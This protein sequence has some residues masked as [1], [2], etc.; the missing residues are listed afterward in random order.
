M[1]QYSISRKETSEYTKEQILGELGFI[2][3]DVLGKSPY[4]VEG[5]VE[6]K[7]ERSIK[8]DTSTAYINILKIVVDV[9]TTEVE[10][11]ER[12]HFQNDLMI[13]I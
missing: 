10:T 8:E 2:S 3:T 6:L 9:E 7:C 4:E 5:E 1:Y 13:Q 12:W 11:E